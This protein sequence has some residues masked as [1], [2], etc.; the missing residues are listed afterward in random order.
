MVNR[1]TLRHLLYHLA[2]GWRVR[3]GW[4][5]TPARDL[6][7]H[8]TRGHTIERHI[9]LTPAQLR[10]RLQGGTFAASTFWDAHIATA[11]IHFAAVT[12]FDSLSRWFLLTTHPRLTLDSLTPCTTSIGWGL[13]ATDRHPRYSKHVTIVF[14]RV[15]ETFY[16]R[17]AYPKVV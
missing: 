7:A 12:N 14:E 9:G 1:A 15:A 10:I 2:D 17:T 3:T 6:L 11:S 8:E 5:R 4:H 13:L 16:I